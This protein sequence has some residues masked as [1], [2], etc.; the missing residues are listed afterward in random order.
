MDVTFVELDTM[1]GYEISVSSLL[2]DKMG[3]FAT[4]QKFTYP[5]DQKGE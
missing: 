4:L 2:G 1:T 3:E 5:V